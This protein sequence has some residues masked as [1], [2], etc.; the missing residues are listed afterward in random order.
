MEIISC[1][2][3]ISNTQDRDTNYIAKWVRTMVAHGDIKNIVDPRLKGVYETNSIWKAVE[4]A[5]ACVSVDSSERP[6]MNQVVI[7]LKNSLAMELNQRSESRP[8]D[9]KDSI[10]M[11]SITM[12]MNAPHSSPMP[13]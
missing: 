12:V 2:P 5:L 7:E 4:V 8:L 10:E 6:T 9:S 11:M 1:R 13:R 3:V